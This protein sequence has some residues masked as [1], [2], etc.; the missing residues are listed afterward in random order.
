MNH[1]GRLAAPHLSSTE[2]AS[3]DQSHLPPESSSQSAVSR[4]TI[5][6]ERDLVLK[7]HTAS[8]EH[9]EI[10]CLVDS[11]KLK[12]ASRFFNALLGSSTFQEGAALD[13]GHAALRKSG[14]EP[15]AAPEPSLPHITISDVG[16][17]AELDSV[18]ELFVDFL[19]ILHGIDL[20]AKRPSLCHIANLAVIADRFGCV[21]CVAEYLGRKD[22]FHFIDA[23]SRGKSTVK[24]S[25]DRLR[26]KILAGWLLNVD[27]WFYDCSTRLVIA[28]S[29]QWIASPETVIDPELRG[30]WWHLP[31]DIEVELLYRRERLLEAL[32]SLPIHF[33]DLYTSK[34]R[35]CKLGYDS[36]PQCDS[37]QLGEM[38]RF[39]TRIGV[40]KMKGIAYDAEE[41]DSFTGDIEQLIATMRQC[42]SYQIDRNHA[43]CGI[44]TKLIPA[45]DFIQAISISESGLC[46]KCWT[47]DRLKYRWSERELGGD[48]IFM[49]SLSSVGS[50]RKERSC[51]AGHRPARAFF[52]ASSRDWDPRP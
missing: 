5:S 44:R 28:G 4:I 48:W 26:Q 52:S 23:R 3:G 25:E 1:D 21:Q 41:M 46:R 42:P 19:R 34:Q 45:L 16:L 11:R 47:D 49:R 40:L 36:S 12:G 7:L 33:I 13:K 43:H 35:Q 30:L 39:F 2:K 27:E 9:E 20:F 22:A 8:L 51:K 14:L 10:H 6:H 18:H 29:C 31:D 17:V 50:A 37:F 32:S 24:T 15:S 38:I